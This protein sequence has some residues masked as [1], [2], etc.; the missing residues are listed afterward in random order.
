M[1]GYPE[2]GTRPHRV[3]DQ[4]HPDAVIPVMDVIE[5]PVQVT[6]RGRLGTV[7]P[8]YLE[9]VPPHLD[10]ALPDRSTYYQRHRDHPQDGRIQHGHGP[11]AHLGAAV[12]YHHYPRKIS[13]HPA[14]Y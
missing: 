9:P 13:H 10:P 11:S 7:P 12:R 6:S 1:T 14:R 8:P 3:P 5:Q 4:G 2:R